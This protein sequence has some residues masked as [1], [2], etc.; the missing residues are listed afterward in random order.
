MESIRISTINGPVPI[1]SFVSREAKPKVSSIQRVDGARVVYVRANPATGVVA[2]NKLQ[3]ISAWL[4]ENPPV[5]G[6]FYE[7]RGA[8]EEQEQSA[9]FLVQA[10][11]LA[12]ALMAILLVTPVSY[13]H[14]T[15]PTNREV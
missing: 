5:S 13:T 11:S 4:A 15:L 7:F 10:F 2:D 6:V 14:L 8:N 1:S 9:A 3:E 12:M